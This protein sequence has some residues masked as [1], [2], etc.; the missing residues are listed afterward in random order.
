MQQVKY[1]DIF[2]KSPQS[3]V[4]VSAHICNVC[5][6]LKSIC[7]CGGKPNKAVCNQ[8]GYTHENLG[9]GAFRVRNEAVYGKGHPLE[10][11]SMAN[12][13]RKRW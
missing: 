9:R 12:P 6:Q 10:G 11:R 1:P 8:L 13:T 5:R 4:D 2:Y 7:N 3:R